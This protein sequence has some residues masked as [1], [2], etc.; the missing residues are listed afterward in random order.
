MKS[1]KQNSV[2]KLYE[3]KMGIITWNKHNNILKF[4]IISITESCDTYENFKINLKKIYK[5]LKSKHIKFYQIYDAKNINFNI[6]D[7]NYAYK[8][9]SFL[10][11]QDEIVENLCSAVAIINNINFIE[12]IINKILQMYQNKIPVKLVK[13]INDANSFLQQYN[14][15]D[16]NLKK[17]IYLV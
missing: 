8:F 5:K 1:I 3:S 16:F 15:N 7:M 11:S 9:A 4:K 2:K 6:M 10:K 14:L 17:N 13:N 12:L